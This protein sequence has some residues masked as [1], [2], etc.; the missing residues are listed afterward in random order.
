MEQKLVFKVNPINENIAL[1]LINMTYYCNFS[2]R[3]CTTWKKFSWKSIDTNS[4]Y[5]IIDLIKKLKNNYNKVE[6]ALT[7]WEP[8]LQ[9]D[10]FNLLNQLLDLNINIQI[11]TNGLILNTKQNELKE[12]S[13]NKNILNLKFNITYHFFEY[14]NKEVLF[15]SS[16]KNLIDN[17]IKFWI[18]FLLP[19]KT[20]LYKFKEIENKIFREV[21]V[22]NFNYSLIKQTNWKVSESYSKNILNYFYKNNKKIEEWKNIEIIYEDKETEIYESYELIDN[23]LNKF[24]WFK[25]NYFSKKFLNLY[26]WTDFYCYFWSCYSL[27]RLKYTIDE[28]IVFLENN[29]NKS[30]ICWD[31]SCLCEADFS[32]PKIKIEKYSKV[33]NHLELLIK[34]IIPIEFFINDITIWENNIQILLQKK[35][36]FI[37]VIVEKILDKSIKY[38]YSDWLL[39]YQYF[40]KNKDNE[41]INLKEDDKL[42]INNFIKKIFILNKVFRKIIVKN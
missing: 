14:E 7:W 3:Y 29:E 13:Y 4:F 19:D 31:H 33:K 1:V 39:W 34:K 40:V 25:C 30:I 36:I 10:F 20:N 21:D 15:I 23:N 38:P 18:N 28:V 17:N 9:K 26:I 2:C 5:K 6:L 16:L 27:N 32:T 22:I 12:L 11:N 24:S 37:F 41:I 35:E 8:T 42:D